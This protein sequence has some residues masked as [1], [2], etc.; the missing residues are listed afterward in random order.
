MS[1]GLSSASSF[2]LFLFL[3]GVANAQQVFT[4]DSSGNGQLT[5]VQ[6]TPSTFSSLPA[7]TS[8]VEGRVRAITDSTTG[9][10]GAVISGG[11]STHV[12]AYCNGA[13]WVV[14][15]TVSSAATAHNIAVTLSCTD[16]SG[17]T[18]AYTCTTAP[19]FTP[20]AKDCLW[21]TPQTTN[22]GASTLNVNS[23]STAP[24]QK[25][26]GSALA[27]GDLVGGKTEPICFDGTNWQVITIGNPPGAGSGLTL[28]Y[29][30]LADQVGA[31]STVAST[32]N[33]AT[34]WEFTLPGSII[35]TRLLLLHNGGG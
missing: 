23:T 28:S 17:S 4:V 5:T 32:A 6:T 3:G 34:F 27:S 35:S 30:S 20:A 2:V 18:T 16:A 9:I 26:L 8:G 29:F 14:A 25:W 24:L 1:K 22:T 10:W 7:C 33:T 21:F 11:G 12:N 15:A 19:N 31:G 13:S